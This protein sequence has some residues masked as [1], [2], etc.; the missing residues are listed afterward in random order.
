[1]VVVYVLFSDDPADYDS[2]PSFEGVFKTLQDAMNAV[3][4]GSRWYYHPQTGKTEDGADPAI[5]YR[6][7]TTPGGFYSKLHWEIHEQELRSNVP[8]SGDNIV[9]EPRKR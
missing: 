4:G 2:G 5:W 7:K 3:P 8:P 6:K 1:M 9:E